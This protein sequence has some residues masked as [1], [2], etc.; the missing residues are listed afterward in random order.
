MAGNASI[1]AGVTVGNQLATYPI[2]SELILNGGEMAS[3][4]NVTTLPIPNLKLAAS[5]VSIT[6]KGGKVA[7]PALSGNTGNG[8]VTYS[9]SNEKVATINASTGEVTAVANGTA[10]ATVAVAQTTTTA[11]AK[12]VFNVVV[13][14]QDSDA[15]SGGSGSG[16]LP[17]ST[18]DDQQGGVDY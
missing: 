15:S 5:S 16:S 12:V 14:G 10:V 4:P 9:I 11:A 17:G 18:G 1:I 6:T 2:E 13:S 3:R 7:A 8:N